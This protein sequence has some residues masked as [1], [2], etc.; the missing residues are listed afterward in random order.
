MSHLAK[1][2]D[3][4]KSCLKMTH[5]PILVV[6]DGPVRHR[7]EQGPEGPIA[8]SVVVGVEQGLLDCHRDGLA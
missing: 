4:G 1:F 6:E 5:L 8:A 7:V 3:K 2:S